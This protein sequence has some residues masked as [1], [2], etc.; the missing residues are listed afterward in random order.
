MK[1]KKI[2]N[3]NPRWIAESLSQNNASLKC[4]KFVFE[5]YESACESFSFVQYA[6]Q[7]SFSLS[8]DINKSRSSTNSISGDCKRTRNKPFLSLTEKD[9]KTENNCEKTFCIPII[10]LLCIPTFQQTYSMEE[11]LKIS[12]FASLIVLVVLNKTAFVTLSGIFYHYV[13]ETLKKIKL[14]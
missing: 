8:A 5:A 4:F 2:L 12:E 7:W 1:Q 11:F 3:I 14:L 6:R 9:S 10:F 13:F